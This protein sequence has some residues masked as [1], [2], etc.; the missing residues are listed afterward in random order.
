MNE[1][2]K[3]SIELKCQPS[4]LMLYINTR[5]PI[6][7]VVK[8]QQRWL[9]GVLDDAGVDSSS[10]EIVDCMYDKD[11]GVA[12]IAVYDKFTEETYISYAGTNYKADGHKDIICRCCNWY[13]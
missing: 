5:Q 1:I 11:S 6:L 4:Y 3:V 9:Q 13:Q 7:L 12:A 10:Y 2:E 8:I